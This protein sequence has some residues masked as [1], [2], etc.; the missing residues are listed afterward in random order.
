VEAFGRFADSVCP[1]GSHASTVV[2]VISHEL[3]HKNCPT[4]LPVNGKRKSDWLNF[5]SSELKPSL[6][7]YIAG[8]FAGGIILLER[9]APPVDSAGQVTE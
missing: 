2:L 5:V 7:S 4:S 1:V 8:G 6:I 9:E 3:I